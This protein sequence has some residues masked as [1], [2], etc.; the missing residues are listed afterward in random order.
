MGWFNHQLDTC[1]TISDLCWIVL[2]AFKYSDLLAKKCVLHGKQNETC[3]F[4]FSCQCLRVYGPLD[5]LQCRSKGPSKQKN[6]LP[7]CP[8]FER[9]TQRN[10]EKAKTLLPQSL[11]LPKVHQNNLQWWGQVE[12]CLAL[13]GH[14]TTRRWRLN[15]T[16]LVVYQPSREKL[17]NQRCFRMPGTMWCC[18]NHETFALWDCDF[19]WHQRVGNVGLVMLAMLCS[20]R[21][22]PTALSGILDIEPPSQPGGTKGHGFGP[23]HAMFDRSRG[24]SKTFVA[25]NQAN[26]DVR[27]VHQVLQR[28]WLVVCQSHSRGT[29]KAVKATMIAVNEMWEDYRTDHP[30]EV[31]WWL[32][33]NLRIT[34]QGDWIC[35]FFCKWLFTTW[36]VS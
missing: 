8:C 6:K 4:P 16:T 28:D 1:W 30:D 25:A 17:A 21:L 27:P 2:C 10:M 9:G 13:P 22:K 29:P 31:Q 12:T 34:R 24:H 20:P 15:P 14:G 5:I 18:Q 7:I 26:I 32:K 23:H 36:M 35:S 11:H 3:L 19:Q 33:Q